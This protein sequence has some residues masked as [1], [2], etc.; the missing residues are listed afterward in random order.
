MLL[1]LIILT[2]TGGGSAVQLIARFSSHGVHGTVQFSQT[3]SLVEVETELSWTK[4]EARPDTVSWAVHRFPVDYR[5]L[6]DRCSDARIGSRVLNLDEVFGSLSLNGTLTADNTTDV[7]NLIGP[8][9][10]WGQSVVLNLGN[11]NLACSTLM[12]DGRTSV[13]LAEARFNGPVS[14]SVMF[15]WL[16]SSG[17][18][19]S[20]ILTDLY[21]THQRARPSL[22]KW[23]IFTTDIL[24]SEADKSRR[25]CNALQVLYQTHDGG[26][27]GDLDS[28][29]GKVNIGVKR[30]ES[31]AGK[32]N[33]YHSANLTLLD[34]RNKQ[35]H[36]YLVLYDNLH[37]ESYLACARI[38]PLEPTIVKSAM[39]TNGLKGTLT[40]QQISPFTSTQVSLWWESKPDGLGG[41]R[42]HELPATPDIGDTKEHRHCQGIGV[43]YNPSNKPTAAEAPL[44]GEVSQDLYAVGDLSGKVGYDN[45][46][47]WDTHLPLFGRHSVA[48]RSFVVYKNND[49]S[50]IE[51]PWVCSTLT[52][53]T[54]H[55]T[56]VP[57]AT[58][59]AIFRYPL[60]GRVIFRQPKEDWTSDT[61]VMV[62]QL[63]HADG[64]SL[65]TTQDHRWGVSMEPPGKDFYD[66]QNRCV[67]AGLPYDGFLVYFENKTEDC[68]SHTPDGFC[69]IG[70]L[71][72]RLGL[73]NIAGRKNESDL[74]SRTLWTDTL[75]PLSGSYSVV[76]RSFVIYDDHGP[77]ARGERLACSKITNV[78]RRKG[79][80][81][82]WFGNGE[83]TTV[84]GKIEL[85]QQ[86]EYEATDVEFTL[87]G[88]IS[89]DTFHIT[90]IPVS[91]Y[92]EFPCEESTIGTMF[93]PYQVRESTTA[94]T[95]GTP[96]LYAIGDLSGKY[97]HLEGASHFDTAVNDSSL[98]LFGQ[99]SVLGRSVTIFRKDSK[100]WACATIERGYAPSEARELRAIASFHHPKGFAW[101]YIRMTQLIH[102]D[103]SASD[104]I[105]EVN[106]KH[107]GEH[108][109]NF[110]QN[111]NW[112][113]YVN[114]VGVDATVQVLHTRCTAAGYMWN[115]YY[116]Q[117]ADPL[118]Q[119]LYQQE[120]GSDHPLR[121]YVGDLSGRLGTIDI[122]G[123]KRVFSDPNFPLEGT[124]SAMGKS[125]V[126]LD[127]NRGPDKF[128]CANIEPDKDTIKYVNV[129][130]PPKFIVSQ[131]LEEVRR[132]MG[133]PEW[134]LTIDTRRT[135]ILHGGSCIQL[136]IHFKGPEANRLEQDFSRLLSVGKLESP[137][138]YIS[139]YLFPANR[140]TRISYKL[141]GADNEKEGAKLLY[142]GGF[143]SRFN[144][145]HL[146]SSTFSIQLTT[147]LISFYIL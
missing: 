62:E 101:G 47:R 93:D 98:M 121:C 142:G 77:K 43:V 61:V 14:G 106:L 130:R 71:S 27:S 66:W 131:F 46:R 57:M 110:T 122:G 32:K 144:A 113:I 84:S 127:K 76:G 125:I 69:R 139:G 117:L 95:S 55:N 126:I 8:S 38:T 28:R 102:Y 52:R 136:L 17:D 143:G 3:Q 9:G 82:D 31:S 147:L 5:V 30:T 116:T 94:I 123:R 36:L 22:H 118:N 114:P 97:G 75:L 105:I 6:E 92:Y 88:L 44:P 103:G 134:L 15:Q 87:G 37:T 34:L 40:L 124:V 108:D 67:S 10:I 51:E 48:H 96:D 137:S 91:E 135:K 145:A 21:H 107:P 23:K 141:C 80:V 112:A 16:G 72:D 26:G 79:V 90:K 99:R 74:V 29:L 18:T 2:V 39:Q 63:V 53:F 109:R 19:D 12:P 59:E 86:T 33:L 41:F 1:V 104:T 85:F 24:D 140:K 70:S 65:K 7:I 132:V 138:L 60:A 25:D 50:G 115:P 83:L 128:A 42:I 64:T 89:A 81:R 120:C 20:A 129:R 119:E 49:T 100:R 73:M 4:D 11:N 68:L 35:R 56:K 146:V 78:F 133:V 45:K 111:H 13:R 58:A 54:R